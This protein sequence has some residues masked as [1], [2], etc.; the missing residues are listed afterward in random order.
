MCLH[1]GFVFRLVFQGGIMKLGKILNMRHFEFEFQGQ[2]DQIN[3][4]EIYN[5]NLGV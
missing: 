3:V 1:D 5:A 4:I 2:S